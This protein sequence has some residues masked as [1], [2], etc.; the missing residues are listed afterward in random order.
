VVA[1]GLVN[2]RVLKYEGREY[3]LLYYWRNVENYRKFRSDLKDSEFATK[4]VP[5]EVKV[6]EVII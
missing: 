5:K 1:K 6:M 3:H 4:Y 2:F